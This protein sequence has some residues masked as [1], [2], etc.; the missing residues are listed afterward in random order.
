MQETVPQVASKIPINNCKMRRRYVYT[1]Y[2][3]MIAESRR[4]EAEIK[5]LEMQLRDFPYGDMF[6]SRNGKYYKW[7]QTDGENQIY[8]PKKERHLAEQL[9]AKKYLSL[10]KEDLLQ[11]KEAVD[12]YLKVHK[13]EKRKSEQLL[14]DES[15][16][17]ELLSPFFTPTSRELLDWMNSPYEKSTEHP[18]HLIYKTHSGNFVRSKSEVIID[19]SLYMNKIPFRYECALQLGKTTIYPDFTLRHPQ[20]GKTLYWEHFGLMDDP[21]YCR[22]AYAK[23]QL[24][25]MNGII[26]S[27]HLITTY[28]TKENPLSSDLVEKMIEYYL[29]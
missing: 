16:Y 14:T 21:D 2:E 1:I 20:T 9:A 26:P 27:V 11:E 29:R 5:S 23:L 4:L 7:Y 15:E 19:M 25:T 17:K 6:C 8:I 10:L 13:M 12:S 18:E 3:K 22:K 28:E 24:Y